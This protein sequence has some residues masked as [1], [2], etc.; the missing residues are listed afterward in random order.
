MQQTSNDSN[1]RK[2]LY[3]GQDD[4]LFEAVALSV[5]SKYT[6]DRSPDLPSSWPEDVDIVFMEL[7]VD[8]QHEALSFINEVLVALKGVPIY[9]LIKSKDA[10]FL[11]EASRYGV[12]GF[13]ECPEEVFNI[14]SILHKQER[15][16]QGKTGNVSVFYSLKGGV[17]TTALATNVASHLSELTRGRTV[18]VDLNTPLGDTSLYLN[19]ESQRIY[20]L[21]DF[22]YNINRFDDKLIYESLTSH[23]T[24]LFLLA[25]P[26][27]VSELDA[28]NGNI[29][30][31]VLQLLRRFFDHVVIDCAS[32]LSDLTLSCLDE[33]DNIVLVAEPSLSAIRAVHT[34]IQLAQKLGYPRESL[35]LVMN[36]STSNPDPAMED[37]IHSLDVE[38]VVSIDND[39]MV[40]ND[41]LKEGLLITQYNPSARVNAQLN[42][43]AQMLHNGSY[44]VDTPIAINKMVLKE[45][46]FFERMKKRFS[47]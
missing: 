28:L 26:S 32:D 16:R 4:D 3:F 19:M 45:V 5:R 17:G 36:R 20:S 37:V 46:S 27:E 42:G 7:D 9:G 38:T 33:S 12:H 29:I 15:H 6:L 18:L 22:V 34:T 24:G 40:F 11:I 31:S 41:S 8:A 30:R 39:Y 13:I 44:S 1:Y 25:L 10:D 21:T 2:A 14:L 35:R 43:L 23:S 47:K